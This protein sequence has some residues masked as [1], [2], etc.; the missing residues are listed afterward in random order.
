MS[1]YKNFV[2][3]DLGAG[4]GRVILGQIDKRIHLEEVHR[5]PNYQIRM[6]NHIHWDLLRLFHEIKEGLK[7]VSAKGIKDISGL[8]VDTWGVDFGLIDRN[9]SL[10]SNPICYRDARTEGMM[11]KAFSHIPKD[12]IYQYTGIQFMQLNTIFQLLSMV[13]EKNP[14]LDITDKLLFMP[15]LIN[16]FLTGEKVSEYTIA[17]TS[18][19][20]NARKRNW[21]PFIFEKLAIP[22]NI[23]PSI[24]QPGTIIGAMR[25]DIL[26]ETGLENVEI[27]ATTCHDTAS[28]VTAVP[29]KSKNWAYLSSGTWSLLGIEI[30]E[31]IINESSFNNDFTN[32]GGAN[33]SIRF[34]RNAMGM[35]LFEK[36]IK[37]WQKQGESYTYHQLI[38]M[39]DKASRFK[40]MI[41]P[42]DST[43]LN[44][45]DMPSAIYNYCKKNNQSIPESKGEYL[46]T[47]FESLA[48][49]YRWIVDKIN[50]MRKTPVEVLHIVGGGSQN[51]IL[52][53]FTA[54]AV[55]IEI[56]TGPVE[57]TAIGNI[58]I[59]ATGKGVISSIDEGR[60]LV[61]ESFPVKTYKPQD[62][63]MWNDKYEKFKE[64]LK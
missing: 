38:P 36:C 34:L 43:F 60:K 40:C 17:S 28:A 51:D 46:R 49:K 18:Q 47:I 32:E 8:G 25:N 27:V 26:D 23:M 63:Q 2:A 29:A 45:P 50:D 61:A 15:D 22:L 64:Y 16:F 12:L 55:G 54:N 30:E 39:A 7:K 59:Q 44:P 42:D 52:N 48:F 11:E 58:L 5:F 33:K 20:I 13:N 6:G 35:W 14:L 53:Q 3:V 56:I 41:N 24:I 4:S 9:D 31:P 1:L 62:H 10:L 19:L 21:E 57:A 37:S